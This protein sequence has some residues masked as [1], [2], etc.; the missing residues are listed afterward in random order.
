MKRFAWLLLFLLP[1]LAIAAEGEAN[2]PTP[3]QILSAIESYR[4][5]PLGPDSQTQLSQVI[6]FASTSPQ[7]MVEI[8]E[9]YLPWHL[10][11]YGDDVESRLIASYIAGNVEYQLQHAVNES[12]PLE[13]VRLM[14]LTYSALRKADSLP[15]IEPLDNWLTLEQEGRLEEAF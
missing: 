10:G 7:V 1:G 5:A 8:S 12:R 2:A 13:G 4:S 9:N 15:A 3:Q 6:A 11:S 14:L